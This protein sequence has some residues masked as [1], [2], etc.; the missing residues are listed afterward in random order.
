[1]PCALRVRGPRSW[2]LGNTDWHLCN[3]LFNSW[4]SSSLSASRLSRSRILSS[5][6]NKILAK[7]S[8][9]SLIVLSST[10]SNFAAKLLPRT[11]QLPIV[12]QV[13]RE[14]VGETRW[15]KCPVT[16]TIPLFHP[17]YTDVN[18]C[19]R[20]GK[21]GYYSEGESRRMI[22]PLGASVHWSSGELRTIPHWET[23]YNSAFPFNGRTAQVDESIEEWPRLHKYRPLCPAIIHQQPNICCSVNYFYH[24]RPTQGCVWSSEAPTTGERACSLDTVNMSILIVAMCGSCWDPQAK[25]SEQVESCISVVIQL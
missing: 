22:D 16:L 5:F 23:N 12:E 11:P 8:S 24:H 9:R 18:I 6:S 25:H 14:K 3:F 4:I 20:L 15:Q 17:Y 19:E 2:A 10:R 13:G 1:M 21:P 7:S